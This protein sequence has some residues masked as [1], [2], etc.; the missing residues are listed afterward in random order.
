MEK[1]HPKL[2]KYMRSLVIESCDR[3]AGRER[4][5]NKLPTVVVRNHVGPINA[6]EIREMK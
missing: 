4:K 1:V 2:E 3:K 6:E 5:G